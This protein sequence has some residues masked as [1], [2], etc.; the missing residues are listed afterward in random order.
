MNQRAIELLAPR[1]RTLS[2]S[3]REPFAVGDVN[4]R[5]RE[6]EREREL[7]WWAFPLAMRAGSNTGI[8]RKLQEVSQ[9]MG[10]MTIQDDLVGFLN[11]PK[12]AQ[13]VDCLVEDICYALMDYQVC[14]TCWTRFHCF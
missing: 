10:L 3:L 5:K 14:T 9:A 1:V 6:K 8:A 13:R 12:N 4:E 2:G 7:E 11:D